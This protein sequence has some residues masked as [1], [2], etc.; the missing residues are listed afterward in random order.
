MYVCK[1]CCQVVSGCL[2]TN[3]YKLRL[4]AALIH[5]QSSMP[6][7]CRTGLKEREEGR[8]LG[9]EICGQS[10][11]WGC[12]TLVG[13]A[14]LAYPDHHA[15]A[16]PLAKSS[17]QD[18]YY[19]IPAIIAINMIMAAASGGIIA[20]LI[21]TWAQ[22]CFLAEKRQWSPLCSCAI[23]AG[24]PFIDYW[25]GSLS[26]WSLSATFMQHLRVFAT[27]SYDYL[28]LDKGK[29]FWHRSLVIRTLHREID[30]CIWCLLFVTAKVKDESLV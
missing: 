13:L 11:T 7:V 21:A 16:N 5:C 20:I 1:Q 24:C 12:H 26:H 30:L 25:R 22:V 15:T 18:P 3:T 4:P 23:T 27:V 17:Q 14:Y 19:N 10:C 9:L 29:G 2:V 6:L 8:F 28:Q